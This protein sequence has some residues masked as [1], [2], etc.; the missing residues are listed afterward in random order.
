MVWCAPRVPADA[1]ELHENAMRNLF[2]TRNEPPG[3]YAGKF[4]IAS[5]SMDDPSFRKTVIFIARHN[6]SLGAMGIVVN[7]VG[8]I[9]M[10]DVCEQ[11]KLPVTEQTSATPI[12]WGGPV[13]ITHGYVLHEPADDR[14]WDVSIYR[15]AQIEVSISQDIV[16]AIA[17]GT[18]PERFYMTIGCASWAP[19]QLEREI[20]DGAWITSDPMPR[21]IFSEPMESRY[22][23]AL[24]LSGLDVSK[25]PGDASPF[26]FNQAGHA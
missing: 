25:L 9:T 10:S 7:R 17:E 22:N 18:G 6:P 2:S 20:E 1:G 26:S 5:P 12:G 14:H 8:G 16:S 3:R 21:V 11:L 24:T 13:N 23:T 4:L 19:G 15:D